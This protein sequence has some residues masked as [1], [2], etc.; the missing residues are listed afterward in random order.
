MT[1]KHYLP[2]S[3]VWHELSWSITLRSTGTD[4][5]LHWA[6]FVTTSTI[7][8]FHSSLLCW[9][10]FQF[11]NKVSMCVWCALWPNVIKFLFMEI[12]SINCG[13]MDLAGKYQ[14]CKIQTSKFTKPSG[15][16]PYSSLFFLLLLLLFFKYYKS[17]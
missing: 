10:E 9:I 14:D 17:S 16:L 11:I 2:S 8:N 13:L 1:S 6:T 3:V 12:T 15:V 7:L 4:K 5:S